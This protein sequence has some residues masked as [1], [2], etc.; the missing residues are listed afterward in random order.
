[1]RMVDWCT[2]ILLLFLCSFISTAAGCANFTAE[3]I[4]DAAVTPPCSHERFQNLFYLASEAHKKFKF[5]NGIV[6]FNIWDGAD[7]VL[8]KTVY[9]GYLRT[10]HKNFIKR[11]GPDWTSVGWSE[12]GVKSFES[13]VFYIVNASEA[14]PVHK[15]IGWIGNV[16]TNPKTRP[17]LLNYTRDYPQYFDF[18]QHNGTLTKPTPMWD[19]VERYAFLLD[20]G[21]NGYSGRLKYLLYSNRP[22]FYVERIQVEYFNHLLQ[23]NVHYIPVKEDL[24]DLVSQMEW[25]LKNPEDAQKIAEN[26]LDFAME[27]LHHDAFIDRMGEAIQFVLDFKNTEGLPP[28]HLY[29][30]P[31]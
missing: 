30:S 18:R 5:K 10:E 13:A 14:S 6:Y 8:D 7:N 27:H 26:A 3:F 12:A 28:P 31:K 21:G 17:L 20:V 9:E 25:A 23:P 19:L 22:L 15:K 4:G 2:S 1:M 11:V 16:H 29:P 24:S